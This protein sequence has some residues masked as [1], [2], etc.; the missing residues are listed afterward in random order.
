MQKQ[1]TAV[2][3]QFGKPV[4]HHQLGIT[5]VYR[6]TK[7]PFS[8]NVDRGVGGVELCQAIS[9]GILGNHELKM[10]AAQS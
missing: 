5:S 3:H 2:G 7:S 1:R 4:P 10:S 6:D 9:Q 8:V